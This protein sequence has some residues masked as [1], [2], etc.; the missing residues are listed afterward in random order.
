MPWIV[1]LG[2]ALAVR[3]V[4]VVLVTSEGVAGD[5]VYYSVQAHLNATGKWFVQPFAEHQPGADHPPLTTAALTPITWLFRDGGFVAAQRWFTVAVGLANVALLG[6]LVRR[7]AGPRAGLIA[8]AL[9]AVHASW[10]M[11]DSLILSEPYAVAAVLGLLS[12]V[13]DGRDRPTAARAAAVGA[14]G[15]L[16]ALGRPEL[17]LLLPLVVIGALLRRRR[18][19]ARQGYRDLAVPFAALVATAALVV[20]PWVG[21]NLARFEARVLVSSNDGFTLLGAN[22]PSTYFGSGIGSYDIRCALAP[23]IPAGFDSSQASELRGELAVDYARAHAERLPLV[24]TARLARLWLVFGVGQ[25]VAGGPAEGRPEWAMWIGVAQHWALLPLAG[26]GLGRLPRPDRRLLLT[27][28]AIATVAGVLIAA[29]W[30][31]RV[32]SDLV[33]LAGA[34]VGLDRLSRRWSGDAGDVPVGGHDLAGVEGQAE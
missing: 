9:A 32:P 11:G 26:Y 17:A 34:A 18:D 23:E 14:A 4:H 28:P 7:L 20:L 6:R 19:P 30:R 25:E 10:W 27:I 16:V 13:V 22:C 24:A 3:A 31:I 29:Y 5:Q 15:G 8:A 12:L 21:W 1:V 33:L 2:T